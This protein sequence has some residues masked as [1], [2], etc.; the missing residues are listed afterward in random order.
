[1]E[2]AKTKIQEAISQTGVKID[3]LIWIASC[4]PGNSSKLFRM[5][6]SFSDDDLETNFPG[7]LECDECF[8]SEKSMLEFLEKTGKTG[9]VAKILVPERTNFKFDKAG[10]IKSSVEVKG[11]YITSHVYGDDID[12][13]TSHTGANSALIIEWMASRFKSS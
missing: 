6:K 8:S 10:D 1:M 9:F 3:Q 2:E 11:K 12:Q 7:M 13:L 5:I 4:I